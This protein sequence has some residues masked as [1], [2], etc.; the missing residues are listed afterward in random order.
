MHVAPHTTMT[1]HTPDE[2]FHYQSAYSCPAEWSRTIAPMLDDPGADAA[3]IAAFM[4]AHA[5]VPTFVRMPGNPFS[6]YDGKKTDPRLGLM[7]R[8]RIY[9]PVPPAPP[10]D[11]KI[12]EKILADEHSRHLEGFELAERGAAGV[13]AAG[14]SDSPLQRL[15]FLDC[16][17]DGLPPAADLA[18]LLAH[19]K[20]ATLDRLAL[21]GAALKE[22]FLMV[23]GMPAVASAQAVLLGSCDK[24]ARRDYAVFA[25]AEWT[26]LRALAL[27]SS[28][29]EIKAGDRDSIW[30]APWLRNLEH[31]SIGSFRGSEASLLI[32][33]G[34]LPNLKTLLL[35]GVKFT[36]EDVRPLLPHLRGCIGLGISAR[37]GV[38]SARALIAAD[39]VP[40][41]ETSEVDWTADARAELV[42]AGFAPATARDRRSAGRGFTFRL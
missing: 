8:L 17:G 3:A 38:G 24:V 42:A 40:R 22:R 27:G 6:L 31:L 2:P 16:Y 18:A 15:R 21:S 10:T 14:L 29:W 25:A 1:T 19:P 37:L 30:R 28:T 41:V 34:V 4:A 12:L 11:K 35:N 23:A 32:D 7:S 20:L 33:S 9:A 36:E 13:L 5:S 26:K 39:C